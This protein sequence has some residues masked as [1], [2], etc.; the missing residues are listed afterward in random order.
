MAQ[1][2]GGARRWQIK[3]FYLYFN[4]LPQASFR[5]FC[6]A[7]ND[8]PFGLTHGM[9]MM[10]MT[11]GKGKERVNDET[12]NESFYCQLAYFLN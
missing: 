10:L 12:G 1:A 8:K 2:Q 5:L 3:A 4:R 9:M 11:M 6:C 7:N